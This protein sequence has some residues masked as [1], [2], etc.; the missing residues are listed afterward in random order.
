MKTF[1]LVDFWIENKEGDMDRIPFQ[2]SL[3]INQEN[4]KYTWLIEVF[5]DQQFLAPFLDFAPK[6]TFNVEV[7]ITNPEN[8]PARFLVSIES[9]KKMDGFSS[10]LMKGKLNRRNTGYAEHLLE[11]LMGSGL[12]GQELLSTFQDRMKDR[13]DLPSKKNK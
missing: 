9:L 3:I 1:K 6:E 13:K 10:V 8:A 2:D 7:V 5:I 12:V 4:E 11:N